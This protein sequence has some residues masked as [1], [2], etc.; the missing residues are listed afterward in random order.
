VLATVDLLTEGVDLPDVDTLLLLRPT[1]SATVFIQQLGRGLRRAEGKDCLTILDF[2]GIQH[3]D[4]RFDLRYQAL[5]GLYRGELR[6]SIEQG[7]DR[8]PAG[9]TIELEEKP[10]RQILEHLRR[11]LGV[12]ARALAGRLRACEAPEQTLSR[13]LEREGLEIEDVYHKTRS[14]RG[15]QDTDATKGFCTY[16]AI[17]SMAGISVIEAS[18]R[19]EDRILAQVG[20]LVHVDDLWRL[21]ALE[22]LAADLGILRELRT[23]PSEDP[24]TRTRWEERL[25]RM[26]LRVLKLKI[27]SSAGSVRSSL[28]AYPASREE[29]GQLAG[30][31]RDSTRIRASRPSEHL[32]SGVPLALHGSY[33]TEEIA[34]AFDIAHTPQTGVVEAGVNDLLL[35]TLDKR[36]KSKVPHLQYQDYAISPRLFHWQSQAGTKRDSRKGRR[37][38]DPAVVPLLFVRSVKADDRGRALPYTFLGAVERVDDTGERPISITYRLLDA[39]IPG[40]LRA[41]SRVAVA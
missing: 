8:L 22:G 13:F 7:F 28:E 21:E 17:R 25:I 6:R 20:R 12:D 36:W 10:R 38:L 11:S 35:V 33:R 14:G 23:C 34:A 27:P 37:H 40:D 16:R 30:A 39:D 3:D 31:I 41:E 1:E 2:V 9:C 19:E 24:V 15:D 32:D 18:D 5:T 4:F 26:L 29:L